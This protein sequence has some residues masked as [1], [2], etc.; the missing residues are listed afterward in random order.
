MRAA[1]SRYSFGR[2]RFCISCERRCRSFLPYRGGEKTRPSLVRTL[3]VVGSDVEN[4]ECPW[5]GSTDRERHLLLYLSAH[6]AFADMREWTVVH[7]APERNFSAHLLGMGLRSYLKCDLLPTANDVERVDITAMPFADQSVNLLIANHVL[8]HVADDHD[9]T[10]EIFRVLAPGGYAILQTP[11]SP[12]LQ[13]TW[14][15]PGITSAAMRLQAHGQEDHVRTFGEDIYSRIEESG[16]S[17]AVST[18]QQ[19]LPDYDPKYYGVNINEPFFLFQR[20][21]NLAPRPPVNAVLQ[22]E[23]PHS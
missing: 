22:D 12:V 21:D 2:R 17:N 8:E 15:D 9:A 11:F 16:L 13:H 19:L 7:F 5:C 14:S 4:F 20:R 18:H 6:S 1:V 3:Q 10:Q 23:T